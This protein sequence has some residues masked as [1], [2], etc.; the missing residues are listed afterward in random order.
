[1]KTLADE[2]QEQ[3]EKSYIKLSRLSGFSEQELFSNCLFLVRDRKNPYFG[4]VGIVESDMFIDSIQTYRVRFKVNGRIKR[5]TF[6]A[7]KDVFHNTDSNNYSRFY[8]NMN[9]PLVL[10]ERMRLDKEPLIN[11]L[12]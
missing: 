8:Y 11:E 4:R 1:M 7:D 3:W 9:A 2:N 5:A 12:S 6:K 10:E